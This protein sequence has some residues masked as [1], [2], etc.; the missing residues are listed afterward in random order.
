METALTASFEA[1]ASHIDSHHDYLL[2]THVGPDGDGL[3][4]AFG[5]YALLSAKG[6]RATIVIVDPLPPKFAF[7]T[8]GFPAQALK[9]FPQEVGPADLKVHDALVL[10]D[11]SSFSRLGPLAEAVDMQTVS[12]V[13]I[14][15]HLGGRQQA[16]VAIVDEAATATA[17]LIHEL[18]GFFGVPVTGPAARALYVALLT[19]TGSFRFSNTSPGVHRLVAE[20]MEHGLE[21]HRIYS[22]LYES[23]P[24][25][26]LGLVGHGLA[27]IAMEEDGRVVYT[28]L[29]RATFERYAAIPEDADGLV[30]QI[31]ALE[32]AEVAVLLYEKAVGDV[33][34]S[35]RAKNDA[36]VQ[37]LAAELGGG[38]HRK[39]AGATFHGSL[40]DARTRAVELARKAVRGLSR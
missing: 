1:L 37:T 14:D 19:E 18:Y 6:K 2:T 20:L 29:D 24:A 9:S 5:L 3:G 34:I 13:V 21:P 15:H 28:T 16:D 12:T 7:L 33:K 11:C 10:L 22:Q 23:K 31:L 32:T 26:A 40:E 30:N 25:S 35:F 39:A 36:D 17:S 38:G 27:N 4:S 8:E